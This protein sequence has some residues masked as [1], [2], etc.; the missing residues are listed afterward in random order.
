MGHITII[1]VGKL[2][3]QY[4]KDAVQEYTKRLSRYDKIDLIEVQDE[5]TP[6]EASLLEEKAIKEKEGKR[7]LEKLPKDAAVIVLR[8]D[9]Q[10]LSST[11]LA[12]KIAAFSVRGVSHLCF[13]IGGSL[14]LSDEVLKKADWGLSFSKMTFPH[15]LMKVILLEQ[16][17]RAERINHHEP[18]HK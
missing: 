3:E 2:K 9:G 6:D 8:I 17:Y 14:G 18:Y 10:M 1:S 13:V 15:Q 4:L 12:D 5:K 7:I 11:E 16:L